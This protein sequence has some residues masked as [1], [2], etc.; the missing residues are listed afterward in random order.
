ML[1]STAVTV[2]PI[3]VTG[4]DTRFSP[5]W[6]VMIK[7]MMFGLPI[8]KSASLMSWP[9]FPAPS[10]ATTLS[11]HRGLSTPAGGVHQYTPS[12]GSFEAIRVQ[13]GLFESEVK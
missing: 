8:V 5:G 3:G 7:S 13:T 9:E 6:R 2:F 1:W 10:R 4:N 11:R 12:F